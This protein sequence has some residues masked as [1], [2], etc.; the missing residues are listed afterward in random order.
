MLHV[1][2]E[3]ALSPAVSY[4]LAGSSVLIVSLAGIVFVVVLRRRQRRL[5]R[6]RSGV[7]VVSPPNA[8][9][10]TAVAGGT[11]PAAT[12]SADEDAALTLTSTTLHAV[13]PAAAT[14][15]GGTP[16]AMLTRP[17]EGANGTAGPQQ[18][19]V[20]AAS[21]RGGASTPEGGGDRVLQASLAHMSVDIPHSPWALPI[22]LY[23]GTA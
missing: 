8:E 13:A 9:A 10:A 20:A 12:Y 4:A 23:L 18:P 16:L 21:P 15:P 2:A 1:L 3:A 7:D 11:L 6:A 14:P 5:K 19:L 22:F 17:G